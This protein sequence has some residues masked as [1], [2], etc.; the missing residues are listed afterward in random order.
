MELKIEHFQ[1]RTSSDYRCTVTGTLALT[2][3]HMCNKVLNK[4]IVCD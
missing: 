2:V 3:V 4:T 1:D